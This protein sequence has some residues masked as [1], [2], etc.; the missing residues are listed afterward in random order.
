MRTIYCRRPGCAI[1]SALRNVVPFLGVPVPIWE[2]EF[3]SAAL[4]GAIP[5][6]ASDWQLLLS[7]AGS[8]AAHS[9]VFGHQ[10]AQ[11]CSVP[12]FYRQHAQM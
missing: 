11:A 12:L 2:L 9:A 5:A 10:S 1:N 8:S 3:V 4:L 6:I 7:Q